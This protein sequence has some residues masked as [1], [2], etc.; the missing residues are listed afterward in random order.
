METL[1][2]IFGSSVRIKIM[3]LFMF[4]SQMAFENKD[5]V[6]R[7]KVEPSQVRKEVALLNRIGFIKRKSFIKEVVKRKV[8]KG[9]RKTQKK[10][11]SGW[12]VDEN[13]P[14][15]APLRNLLMDMGPLKKDVILKKFTSGGRMKLVIL[16]GIFIKKN[17]SRVDILIV[18]NNI[19]RRVIEKGIKVLE[20]EIGKE[21]IYAILDTEEFTYRIGIY[22]KFIRDVL[23][24]PHEKILNK[25]G[26]V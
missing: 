5:I 11:V 4:N 9:K 12:I 13:F 6:I 10:K 1:E 18:G 26:V 7:S 19:K 21:L 14:F 3:R 24:Y 22:D 15:M 17:D 2:K 16:A 20:S 25:I 8:K 23:D